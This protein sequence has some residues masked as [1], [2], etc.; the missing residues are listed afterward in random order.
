MERRTQTNE[1]GRLAT[2]TPVLAQV[3]GEAHRPLALVE[4]G[5]SAGLCLYPDRYDYEWHPAGRLAGSGGPT[6][7]C[8][9]TGAVPVPAR[10]PDVTWRGGVDLNPVDP[11]DGDAAEWLEILVWPEQ[12]ER[13]ERLRAAIDVARVEPPL[14]DRGDLLEQLPSLVR[15]AAPHGQVVVQHSAVIA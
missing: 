11:T 9:T 6:L 15:R 8:A 10:H 13:R 2:L 3:A 1:V 4:V 5:A 7:H 12:E 14:L